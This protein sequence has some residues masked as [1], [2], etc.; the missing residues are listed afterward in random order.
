LTRRE[1][2]KKG[3][4]GVCG[5][6]LGSYALN[7]Y[8]V[9]AVTDKYSLAFKNDAP[10]E[11]WKWSKEAEF[12]SSLQDAVQCNL[13]PHECTIGLN[14]RGFCRARANKDGKLYTLVYGNPSAVHN[15]P[16]EKKPLYHFLPGTAVLSISTSGCNL[17]CKN[18]Q[19]WNI[20]QFKPEETQNADLMPEEVVKNA[21]ELGSKS[22]AYT[23]GEPNIFYEYMLD[24]SKL[25]KKAGLRNVS[26]TA[27]YINE[28][29]LRKLCRYL[30]ASNIDLKG[31]T[32]EF[33]VKVTEARL[34]PVL[35]S[36]KILKDEGVWFEVTN[37]IVPTLSDD[38]GLYREMV[39]WLFK[40]VGPDH[41]VHI[42]R[43]HSAYKLT[44]L[45]A[46]SVGLLHKLRDIAMEE[47]MH[48]VYIGNIP[49]NLNKGKDTICPNCGKFAIRRKGYSI[50]EFNLI[51]GVCK[52]C[53][54]AIAGVW[55]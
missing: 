37:L 13:C 22:I 44:H 19:N 6:A 16:I 20:S 46:T 3:V 35:D 32:E 47:G 2:I 24:S 55:K 11:L 52:F 18:C 48:Y 45:P 53:G 12:Y 23:Y 39:K 9:R 29:P 36:I 42:S 51:D 4:I 40:N 33:Y 1:F 25:A 50:T 31:F 41:P 14:D 43:F 34:K 54:F 49:D 17:R 27:G 26:V 28:K 5:L 30:D 15:D 10:S 8:S 21:L 7:R 38:E